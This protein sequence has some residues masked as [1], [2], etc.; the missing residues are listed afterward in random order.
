MRSSEEVEGG[1][2]VERLEEGGRR[3]LSRV[4]TRDM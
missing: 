2:G 1:R 4:A 3:R